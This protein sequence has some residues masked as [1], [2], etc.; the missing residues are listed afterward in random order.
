LLLQQAIARRTGATACYG[1]PY[2]LLC[3]AQIALIE[4]GLRQIIPGVGKIRLRSDRCLVSLGR[5]LQLV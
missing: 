3:G 2:G 1:L 4:T 5:L